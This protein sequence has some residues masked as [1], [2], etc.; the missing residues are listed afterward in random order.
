[1]KQ[2]RLLKDCEGYKAG[3]VALVENNTAHRLI[4]T[5]AARLASLNEPHD[6]MM[7]GKNKGSEFQTK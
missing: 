6:R 4:D 2:I 3:Q 5:G 1:M 7:G